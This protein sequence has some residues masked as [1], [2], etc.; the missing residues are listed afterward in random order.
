MARFVLL[1]IVCSWEDMALLWIRL[2]L[3]TA[4]LDNDAQ[5]DH[6]RQQTLLGLRR[7]FLEILIP[8]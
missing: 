7:Q 8:L 5:D 3:P 1:K 4:K 6:Q 2:Q